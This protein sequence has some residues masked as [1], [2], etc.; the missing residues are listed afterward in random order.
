ML[1]SS[2]V[3]TEEKQGKKDQSLEA[4]NQLLKS[5]VSTLEDHV[6]VLETEL[7]N[8]TVE[9]EHWKNL[10]F[11]ATHKL[12]GKKSEAAIA[13]QLTLFD[14]AET[15]NIAEVLEC[16]AEDEQ[17]TEQR[18]KTV[19]RRLNKSRILT[20]DANTPIVEVVHE[21]EAPLCHCG[22]VMEKSGYFTRDAIA[23]IPASKAI[24][25]HSTAQYKC[26]CCLGDE[27]ESQ[28]LTV[29]E[30]DPSLLKGTICEPSLLATVVADKMAHGLPLYRQE[31]RFK[32][33]G[34]ELSRQVMSGWMMSVASSLKPL[35]AALERSV[36]EYPLW[37]VDE[38]ALQVLRI[39]GEDE[40]KQ[41]F[42][43]VRTTTARDFTKGP[44]I[45]DYLRRRTNS[46]IAD[47]LGDYS[48]AVQS[49]GLS[50]YATAAKS[51]SFTHLGCLV[52]AR[53]KFADILKV[54]KNN[55]LAKE[56]LALYATFFHHEGELLERQRGKEPLG[57]DEY[58]RVR[59][60]ILGQDLD[61]IHD[62]LIRYK[63]VAI[64]KSPMFTAIEYSL[65]RWEQ[66][67][68]FLDIPYATSGNNFAENAIRPFVLA[69]KGFLFAQTPQGAEASALY[70]SLTE[71]C[72]AMGINVQSYLTHLFA[73][74]GSCKSDAD[75]DAMIPGKA[76]LSWVD[77]YQSLL[78]GAKADPLRTE[79]YI[80]R[81]K[82]Y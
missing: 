73:K 70:F 81:G 19:T 48:H 25:R 3:K 46:S 56:V 7:E 63:K 18:V 66:L 35:R 62:W 69:R 68:A 30:E 43:A 27:G 74:A 37:N 15:E 14:E 75:W 52:H 64:A 10:Y 38:T 20:V 49:D 39:E 12:Y 77:E 72:K 8:K 45:F 13:S 6:T 65:K 22:S 76:D 2:M 33:M 23:V 34:V 4:E 5:H 29:T 59:R 21:G 42:M 1:S 40:P 71:S 54:Q 79:P 57:E 47:L 16:V 9:A 26:P 36:R 28:T 53:R 58:L 60:K 24:V 82:R 11:F 67:N 61:A 51:G 55:T 41:C 17:V 32:S 50:G 80:L 44:V 78:T 31:S